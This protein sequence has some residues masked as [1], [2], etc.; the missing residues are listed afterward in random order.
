M[1]MPL[2]KRALIHVQ[3]IFLHACSRCPTGD[4]LLKAQ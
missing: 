1:L 3:T 4:K 2:G